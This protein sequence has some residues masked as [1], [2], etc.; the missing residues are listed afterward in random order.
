MLKGVLYD[1][2]GGLSLKVGN[3]KLAKLYVEKSLGLYK[4]HEDNI[5]IPPYIKL[6]EIYT[7]SGQREKVLI[8]FNKSRTL[9]DIVHKE[10]S[11]YTLLWYQKYAD[12]F[13]K[14]N[15]ADSA[16]YYQKAYSNMSDP[17]N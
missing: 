13:Q 4:N 14:N 6:A 16:F 3:L 10:P 8:A 15:Q 12:Y 11:V 17:L 1:N 2:L 7:L 9:L 5:V